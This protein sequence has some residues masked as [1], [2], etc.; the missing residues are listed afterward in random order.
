MSRSEDAQGKAVLVQEAATTI[1]LVDQAHPLKPPAP[2]ALRKQRQQLIAQFAD[3]ARP[4]LGNDPEYRVPRTGPLTYC[5]VAEAEIAAGHETAALALLEQGL[6]QGERLPADHGD[7]V[8]GAGE[9]AP[10]HLFAAQYLV[11]RGQFAKAEPHWKWLLKNEAT[12]AWGHRL[13]GQAALNEGQLDE[14]AGHFEAALP[15]FDDVELRAALAAID[16]RLGRWKQAA[17]QLK[18][19][20]AQRNK[21]ERSDRAVVQRFLGTVEQ[22]PQLL[23]KAD[24]E[25]GRYGEVPPLVAML[26]A[27]KQEPA[28]IDLLAA[29]HQRRGEQQ[30]A[31]DE[32]RAGRAKYPAD[33]G[34][35]LAE[36]KMLKAQS[37]EDEAIARLQKFTEENPKHVDALVMLAQWRDPTR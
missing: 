6:G 30:Q 11:A 28:A 35:L 37:Q 29:Y 22:L 12:V 21:F 9:M 23:G 27:G 3:F 7:M 36:I 26:K 15:Q 1:V 32:L 8:P 24:L 5:L 25:L 14:A 34:L 33:Y 20:L 4:L 31:A 18:I 16:L 19:V 13:A 10:L 2:P 17:E